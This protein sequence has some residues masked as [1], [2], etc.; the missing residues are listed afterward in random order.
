MVRKRRSAKR[1]LDPAMEYQVW[2]SIFD[3]GYDFFGELEALGYDPAELGR[4]GDD[5]EYEDGD[6]SAADVPEDLARDPWTRHGEQWL[7][8]PRYGGAPA[9]AGRVSWAESR[10]GRPWERSTAPRR[11]QR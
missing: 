8:D 3:S 6:T 5:D 2:A 1:R 7:S 4:A 11:R 9:L 10:L